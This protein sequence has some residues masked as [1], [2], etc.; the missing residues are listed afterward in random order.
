MAPVILIKTVTD[1]SVDSCLVCLKVLSIT[2]VADKN[3][4]MLAGE[5]HPLSRNALNDEIMVL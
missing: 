3:K 5:G 2:D 4:Y 1:A